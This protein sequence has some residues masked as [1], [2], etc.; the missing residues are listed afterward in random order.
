MIGQLSGRLRAGVRWG[1]VGLPLLLAWPAWLV[2][3]PATRSSTPVATPLPAL[4]AATF[5]DQEGR[6]LELAS[7]RGR[8]VVVVYGGRGGIDHHVAWGRRL[9]AELRTRGVYRSE[10]PETQRP[11]Q[12]LALAQMGGIPDAFRSMLRAAI[13]PH[14]ERGYSLWLD[15]DDLMSRLFGASTRGS[16]VVVAD[17]DGWVRL[18]VSGLPDGPSYQ[19]VSDLLKTLL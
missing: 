17:R 18:V 1:L 14:V 15:W 12:I 11:V 5:Q 10:D 3:Q 9:D 19:T 2:A 7:L 6:A 8:V 13:R 4:P 16:T